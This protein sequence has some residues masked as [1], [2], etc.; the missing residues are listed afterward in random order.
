MKVLESLWFCCR[1]IAY[2]FKQKNGMDWNLHKN[3]GGDDY[4]GDDSTK[5]VI[6]GE[7]SIVIQEMAGC[8]ID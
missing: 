4:D 1:N 2:Y 5:K 8:D 7:T 6:Y 3:N